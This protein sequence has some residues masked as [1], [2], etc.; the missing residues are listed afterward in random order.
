MFENT[1]ERAA[2]NVNAR[3]AGDGHKARLLRVFVMAM[4][5]ARTDEIPTVIFDQFDRIADFHENGL[6]EARV[7]RKI[8]NLR[9]ELQQSTFFA[10]W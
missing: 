1:V 7:C 8:E 3:M 5:S 4:A 2:R 9:F 10:R 6:A